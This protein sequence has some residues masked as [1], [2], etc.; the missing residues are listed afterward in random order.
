MKKAFT[1]IELVVAIALLT[2]VLSFSGMIF[3]VSINS[4]RT[5]CANTEI[6]QKLRAI[7]D[8][9][10]TDFKGLQKDAPL[11]IRFE[12][13]GPNRYDQIMFFANGNF[14]STQVYDGSLPGIPPFFPASTGQPVTGNI[15]RIYYGQADVVEPSGG[16][17]NYNVSYGNDPAYKKYNKYKILARRRH[18]LAA[19]TDL[20]P[21]PDVTDDATFQSTFVPVDND[22]FEHDSIFLLRWQI[23]SA[24]QANNDRVIQT[25]F[26]NR[27]EIDFQPQ[28][29]TGLHMLMSQAVSS[30]S[31]QWAYRYS[32]PPPPAPPFIDEYR[33]W[34]SDDPDGI[35]GYGD[36]D[37]AEM[38]SDAFGIYFNMPGGIDPAL[39]WYDH[40]Q[41]ANRYYIFPP[42]FY[43]D[44]LK[45]TFTLYDSKGILEKSKTFTHI[46]YLNN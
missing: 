11:L 34:P 9:L 37:F 15:A 7:T 23:I 21:F 44:A 25:C 32:F 13:G 5:S 26:N 6:M 10:N 18:I 35:P 38:G 36:S 24:I 33:W 16:I 40:E 41:A 39:Y 28:A 14:Q 1:L 42:G 20:F 2:M 8:Q 12:K 17:I 29:M 31:I 46:V 19:D 27:P 45:F 4:H 22:S 30:F 43:P 3:K